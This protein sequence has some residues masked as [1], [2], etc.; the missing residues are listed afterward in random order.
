MGN[1]KITEELELQSHNESLAPNNE[2][3]NQGI[4]WIMKELPIIHNHQVII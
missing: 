3:K 4:I 1:T 2:G